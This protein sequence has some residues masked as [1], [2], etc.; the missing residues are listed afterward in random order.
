MIIIKYIIIIREFEQQRVVRKFE[1]VSCHVL[2]QGRTIATLLMEEE[3]LHSL[4]AVFLTRVMR[5]IIK[6]IA[7]RPPRSRIRGRLRACVPHIVICK[8]TPHPAYSLAYAHVFARILLLSEP[9]PTKEA[10]KYIGC[11]RET[12]LKEARCISLCF[13]IER[14]KE[15][16]K[17]LHRIFTHWCELQL[18]LDN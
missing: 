9:S 3:I 6:Q 11:Y 5:R 8:Y 13:S 12:H 15:R 18:D 4:P 14:R 16:E 7:K 17:N 10:V 1:N 2:P